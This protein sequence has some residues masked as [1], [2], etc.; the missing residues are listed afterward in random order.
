MGPDRAPFQCLVCR[1]EQFSDEEIKLNT[2]VMEFLD[3][4]WANRSGTGLICERCG[5]VHTFAGNQF[6]L[7]DPGRGYPS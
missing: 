7:W 4:E 2:S 1:G 6:E 3:M 5:F